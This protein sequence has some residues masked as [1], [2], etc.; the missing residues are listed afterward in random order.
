MSA[1][2]WL[3]P[4]FAFFSSCTWAVGS[5][6][7][8]RMSRVFTPFQVNFSRALFA[9]PLFLAAVVVANGGLDGASRA[10]SALEP[11]HFG[12]FALSMTASYAIGDVLFL[13]STVSLGVPG[14][15][16]IASGYPIFTAIFGMIAGETIHLRQWA[17]LFVAI[18]GIVAVILSNPKKDVAAEPPPDGVSTVRPWMREKSSGVALAIATALAWAT[19]AYSVARGGAGIDGAVANVVRM[20]FAL[21]LI[22]AFGGIALGRVVTPMPFGFLKK[23]AWLFVLEAFGGSYFYLYGLS[24]SSIVLGSVLASL[25]PVIAVP[26]AV[27]LRLEKFSWIRTAAVA[28]VVVGLALLVQ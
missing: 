4:L 23:Y 21:V 17:G 5:A 3:G 12:W 20:S 22:S 2:L 15:L 6:N 8:S 9:L 28:S 25:A 14:A 26:I 16:A 1:P 27:A 13:W 10:F 7:Y 11:R 18:G 19:N 24:N